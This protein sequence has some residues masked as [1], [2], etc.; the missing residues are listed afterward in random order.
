MHILRSSDLLYNLLLLPVSLDD[1]DDDDDDGDDDDDDDGD[2]ADDDDDDWCFTT[3]ITVITV[4]VI[5]V[6]VIIGGRR[7]ST[8]FFK[9]QV[10]SRSKPRDLF[11]DLMGIS[12]TPNFG[13]GSKQLEHNPIKRNIRIHGYIGGIIWRIRSDLFPD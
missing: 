2:D 7:C 12:L 10:G 3:V 4:T 5:A 11:G 8:H 6:T 1:D 9:S 13:S